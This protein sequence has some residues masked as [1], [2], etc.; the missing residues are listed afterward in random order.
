MSTVKPEPMNVVIV[1]DHGSAISSVSLG[2][3]Q[4]AAKIVLGALSDKDKVQLFI[5]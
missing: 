3:T 1:L 5:Y 2:I 4:K